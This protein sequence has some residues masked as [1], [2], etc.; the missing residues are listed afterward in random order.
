MSQSHQEVHRETGRV[1]R[2][3]GPLAVVAVS[4]S[5]AC[6]GCSARGA[7]HTLSGTG[8]RELRAV[9]RIGAIPGDQVELEI[10]TRAGLRAAVWVYLVPTVILVGVAVVTHRIASS[11]LSASDAD[12]AAA[13]G[14]LG[15][16]GLVALGAWVLQRRRGPNLDRYPSVARKI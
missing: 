5:S 14:A 7:C 2:L 1:L 3:E 13:V 10:P 4:K 12:L 11:R 16:L 6:E 8:D 9:N 15:T